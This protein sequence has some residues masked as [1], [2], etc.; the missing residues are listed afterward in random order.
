MQKGEKLILILIILL[1]AINIG[2]YYLSSRLKPVTGSSTNTTEI[3]TK[4]F[5]DSYSITNLN[6]AGSSENVQIR[7]MMTEAEAIKYMSI[8]KDELINL[9]ED[10]NARFPYTELNGTYTFSKSKLDKWL[11]RCH[12]DVLE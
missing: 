1:A 2:G 9:I 8:T 4:R 3:L 6:N 12:V 5:K 7:D 11:E 10:K